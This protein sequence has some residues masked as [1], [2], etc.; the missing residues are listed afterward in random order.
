MSARD[1]R[2]SAPSSPGGSPREIA[3]ARRAEVLFREHMDLVHRRADRMFGSLMIL[4][5]IFA[6]GVALVHSPYAWEGKVRQA[7]AHL[8]AAVVLGGVIGSLPFV[9]TRVRPGWVVTRH[10][11][12]V[13]QMLWSALLIHLTGGRIETHF[14]VFGSLAFLA[15]YR[16]H[17]VLVPATIVVTADHFVRAQ[18]W[19]E[20]VYGIPDPSFWRFLEHC[21]WVLFED[22]VLVFA[23]LGSVEDMRA[24][25]RRGAEMEA[26]SAVERRK[27]AALD[28]ALSELRDKQDRLVRTEKLAAVGQLAASVGHEMRNPL[29]AIRGAATYIKKRVGVGG[30]PDLSRVP[31]FLGVIDREVAECARFVSDLLDFARERP[32]A[33]EPCPL[34]PLVDEASGVVLGGEGRIANLLP[35]DLPVPLVDRA[36]LRQVFVNLL[37]NAVDALSSHEKGQVRVEAAGGDGRPWRITVSDDGAGIPEDVAPKIFEPLY[38]T[39]NKGTGLGLAIVAGIV[40]RHGGTID[41][42]SRPGQGATFVIE[43]PARVEAAA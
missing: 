33:L 38:T 28:L 36:Q 26:L 3:L 14:H 25:A 2:G 4:Q 17:R 41:V 40:K 8:L 20:S 32:P 37:Q 1:A 16:D 39:K 23:C 43:L 21:F 19:P 10:A 6:V 18:L 27:S 24:I 22:A 9:L 35:D 7:H 15:V 11:V 31:E 34:R 12:A 42:A 13:S 30:P 29:A 5:W